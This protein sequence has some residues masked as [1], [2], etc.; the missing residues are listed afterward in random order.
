MVDEGTC[1][2]LNR[3][4]H[5]PGYV[6]FGFIQV[7]AAGHQDAGVGFRRVAD[8]LALRLLF[9]VLQALVSVVEFG[10]SQL[11]QVLILIVRTNKSLKFLNS[12]PPEQFTTQFIVS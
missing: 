2:S 1:R 9:A 5:F 8:P 7:R 11:G 3:A 4:F 6:V 12:Q 10:L